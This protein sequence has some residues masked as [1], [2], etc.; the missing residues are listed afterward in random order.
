MMEIS[1]T[2]EKVMSQ[3]KSNISSF[4]TIRK[5]LKVGT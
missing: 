5:F 4:G 3:A 2:G 1:A